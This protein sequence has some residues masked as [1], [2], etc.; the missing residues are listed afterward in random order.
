MY[1]FYTKLI[2]EKFFKHPGR[3]RRDAP[4]INVIGKLSDLMMGQV[5]YPNYLDPRSPIVDVNINGTI[6]PH[7]LIDNGADVM[8][9]NT[10]L[11]PNLQGSLRKTTTVLQL[12]NC[13]TV[14]P[15]GIV[16]DVMVSIDSWEYLLRD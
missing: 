11:N 2:K 9:K 1:L 12:V 13:T 5:T 15:K 16:E 6:V 10:M 3:R 14:T 4:T 8:T 7:T